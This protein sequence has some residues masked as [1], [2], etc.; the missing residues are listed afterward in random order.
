MSA[1]MLR[2]QRGCFVHAVND[3][4]PCNDVGQVLLDRDQRKRHV[5]LAMVFASAHR[6]LQKIGPP[7]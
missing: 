3:T 6:A 5:G 2:L 7:P 4:H 1:K